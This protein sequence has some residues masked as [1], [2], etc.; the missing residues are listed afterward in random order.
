MGKIIDLSEEQVEEVENK[1]DE[2]D[3]RYITYKLDGS[4]KI[5]IEEYFFIKRI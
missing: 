2:Y 1:L 4:I 3:K 5:G